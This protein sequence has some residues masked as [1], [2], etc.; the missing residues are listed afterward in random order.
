MN[1]SKLKVIL[2]VLAVSLGIG[3]PIL[4]TVDKDAIHQSVIQ[5]GDA[6]LFELDSTSANNVSGSSKS[7]EAPTVKYV[8]DSILNSLEEA[9]VDISALEKQDDFNTEWYTSNPYELYVI[10]RPPI[11]VA[12]DLDTQHLLKF[13]KIQE[14]LG[15]H[16]YVVDYLNE[17]KKVL[18][19]S[20]KNTNAKFEYNLHYITDEE[21]S[22]AKNIELLEFRKNH[23]TNEEYN[24]YYLTWY[25]QDSKMQ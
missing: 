1:I 2:G 14:S 5:R 20:Y 18:N 15:L 22:S 25:L 23:P 16:K 19:Q 17:V 8:K 11:V 7:R 24:M 12:Y 6:K 13:D 21:Y 10:Q 4:V 3:L 9:K